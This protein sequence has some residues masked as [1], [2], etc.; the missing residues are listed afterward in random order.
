MICLLPVDTA[1]TQKLSEETVRFYEGVL[2]ARRDGSTELSRDSFVF[3][4]QEY[5]LLD[6]RQRHL[7]Q[8][9]GRLESHSAFY[10]RRTKRQLVGMFTIRR[11][12]LGRR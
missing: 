8:R 3:A 9:T 4:A 11:V 12:K 2:A 6:K 5:G 7:I 1:I 10:D